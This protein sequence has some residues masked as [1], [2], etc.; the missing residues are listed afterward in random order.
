MPIGT[1]DPATRGQAHN[2]TALAQEIPAE[3]G[4]GAVL[5]EIVWDWDGVSVIPNCNGPIVSIHVRNTNPTATVWVLLPSKKKGSLWVQIDPSTDSTVTQQGQL[6]TLGLT[7]RADVDRI[8]FWFTD[9]AIN[10]PPA[11]FAVKA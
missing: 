1:C 2:K 11:G 8:G 7:T 5:Y 6:N 4:G 9:P 10:P 3:I